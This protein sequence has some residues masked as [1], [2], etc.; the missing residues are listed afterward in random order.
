[1][2][3][4]APGSARLLLHAFP[5]SRVNVHTD[6]RHE[7]MRG[8]NVPDAHAQA[9]GRRVPDARTHTCVLDGDGVRVCHSL[10]R[11]T[12]TLA[13]AHLALL[14]RSLIPHGQ[15]ALEILTAGSD[16]A[17]PPLD[18][19]AAATTATYQVWLRKMMK[20]LGLPSDEAMWRA[21]NSVE[22]RS[23]LSRLRVVLLPIDWQVVTDL[24]KQRDR[25][26]VDT[27]RRGM[28]ALMRML[29]RSAAQ[30]VTVMM[31]S[32]IGQLH[33]VLQKSRLPMP[34]LTD[35]LVF[36]SRGMDHRPSFA[37][38]LLHPDREDPH[39][40]YTTEEV[41]KWL[42][43]PAVF[44]AGA[45]TSMV[46]CHV[47]HDWRLAADN[48]SSPPADSVADARSDGDLAATQGRRSRWLRLCGDLISK[49][50]YRGRLRRAL[51]FLNFPGF[52]ASSFHFAEGVLS[53]SLPIAFSE[54]ASK[55]E[56]RSQLAVAEY[57]Q[58]C[59]GSPSVPSSALIGAHWLPFTD[60][61]VQWHH[62]GI[63]APASRA[64]AVRTFLDSISC[65][66]IAARLRALRFVRPLL[67]HRG[68]A[69]YM[70]YV[71]AQY[72]GRPLALLNAQCAAARMALT[73]RQTQLSSTHLIPH[74]P[75]TCRT[76]PPRQAHQTTKRLPY[77]M[78]INQ[79][80]NTSGLQ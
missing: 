71:I 66:E 9:S 44:F 62:I 72:H 73:P 61:G 51:W 6:T 58:R 46:R 75:V 69:A 77:F 20:E 76:M 57:S 64:A 28:L 80:L 59:P 2:V 21:W 14:N 36:Q 17:A 41:G 18:D 24:E 26:R 4:R 25:Q 13:H 37:V 3:A 56:R 38:P 39:A 63:V 43:V 35:V 45:C 60:L 54:D 1:M 79:M 42:R 7:C 32:H 74:Q 50:E 8:R 16:A 22:P 65:D 70:L 68:V 40:H 78:I 55:A 19:P 12:P 67:S 23:L 52:A 53:G 27:A 29:N 48:Q 47:L 15:D 33:A 34:D 30:H 5:R 49:E 10:D 11:C 31:Q